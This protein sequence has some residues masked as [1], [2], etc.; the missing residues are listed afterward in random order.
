MSIQENSIFHTKDMSTSNGKRKTFLVPDVLSNNKKTTSNGKESIS[1]AE[2][3]SVSQKSTSNVVDLASDDESDDSL[4]HLMVEEDLPEEEASEL[5][6]RSTHVRKS[7]SLAVSWETPDRP[8]LHHSANL[9]TLPTSRKKCTKRPLP[10]GLQYEGTNKKKIAILPKKGMFQGPKRFDTR[11]SP[12]TVNTLYV[13]MFIKINTNVQHDLN[14]VPASNNTNDVYVS[15]S[16]KTNADEVTASTETC[17]KNGS[18]VNIPNA[19]STS[20]SA[21]EQCPSNIEE[22]SSISN[23]TKHNSSRIEHVQ[24]RCPDELSIEESLSLINPQ[25]GPSSMEDE[26]DILSFC[27]SPPSS[28]EL[29][30]DESSSVR[31]GPTLTSSPR[32][33][34]QMINGK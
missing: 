20:H 19:I 27:D 1:D 21:N 16:N 33:P 22:N 6:E 23:I 26:D 9:P 18:T 28:D 25:G 31:Q 17:C 34:S 30:D 3:S 13:P 5:S 11:P 24:S 14:N 10:D 8:I 29:T 12:N 15:A 32:K 2:K 4:V 7:L